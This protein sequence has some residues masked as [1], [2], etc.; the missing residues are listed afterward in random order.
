M[1]S[2]TRQ[3]LAFSRQQVLAPET[4]DLNVAVADT[5]PMLQNMIGFDEFNK[6]TI[7]FLGGGS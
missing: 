1:A 4:L 3:L 6:L 2:L 5:Q 7:D